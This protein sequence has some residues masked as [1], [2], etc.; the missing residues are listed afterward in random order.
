VTVRANSDLERTIERLLSDP[1]YDEHPLRRALADLYAEFRDALYQME[2]IA[3]ISDRYQS[4]SREST[5]SLTERYAKQL[6]QLEKMARISDRYQAMMRDLNEALKDA[7]TRDALTGI[8]NRRMLMDRL[9]AETARAERMSRPLTI[10]MGDVDRFKAV[11]DVHGH[12]AGDKVLVE[13]ARVIEGNVR[14]YDLCGRWGGEEFMII[15][16]EITATEGAVVVDRVRH[17]IHGLRIPVGE[18]AVMLSASFGIAERKP[19]ESLSDMINR[20]D[21]ALFAA[22]RSGR[23][24]YEVAN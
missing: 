4:V 7:S 8:G 17:A 21:A 11:N 24:R 15:M 13:V 2:R 9:K 1:A 18:S 14:D 3:R 5:L 23:N 12:E 6:R 22:K 20:A 10:A 19:G 16:P